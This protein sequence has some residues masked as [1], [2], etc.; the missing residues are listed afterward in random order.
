[1]RIRKKNFCFIRLHL[2]PNRHLIIIKEG[3]SGYGGLLISVRREAKDLY[4][5]ETGPDTSIEV[6]HQFLNQIKIR[7]VLLHKMN[8][9]IEWG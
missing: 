1:M 9:N 2:G 7:Y 4:Y 6:V 3:I 8:C 5:Y